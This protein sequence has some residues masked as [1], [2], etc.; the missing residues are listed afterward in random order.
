MRYW[1][2]GNEVYIGDP[3][4]DARELTESEYLGE[5]LSRRKAEVRS[6]R[7]TLILSVEWRVRR[8]Q[9][10]MALGLEPTESITPVLEYIQALRE[11]PQQTGFPSDVV[12]PTLPPEA[13]Q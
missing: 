2:T 10:E 4:G 3:F 11:V 7:D 6:M 8:H 1:I 13:P 9:D 5:R 12:W